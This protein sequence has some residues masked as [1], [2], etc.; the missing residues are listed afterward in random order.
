TGTPADKAGLRANDVITRIDGETVTT[1]DDVVLAIRA[2]D[3]GDKI[4][5]TYLR[6]SKEITTSATLVERPRS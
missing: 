3:I 2:H 1:A 4:E 5:L 6:G